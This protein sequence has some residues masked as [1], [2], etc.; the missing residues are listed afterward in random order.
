MFDPAR[1]PPVLTKGLSAAYV[2]GRLTWSAITGIAVVPLA[3]T[4]S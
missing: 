3:E 1:Y 2:L 4:N